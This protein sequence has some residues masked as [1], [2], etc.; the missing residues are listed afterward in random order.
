MMESTSA[1]RPAHMMGFSDAVQNVLMNNY[2]NLNGRASRS[3][4]WWFVLFNFIVNIVTFVIDLTLGTMI[5]YDMGYVGLIAFL[6]LLLPT[7]SVSVRRLHDI[8]K[9]GWWILL[10][11]IPIVNFIGIFVIIVFTIM[12]GEEQPNQYGNVPT[13]TFEQGGNIHTNY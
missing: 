12:E 9:S 2:A 4:Y 10:A 5:T 1:G 11:I 8:G 13:N 6:A 7:V 3:E